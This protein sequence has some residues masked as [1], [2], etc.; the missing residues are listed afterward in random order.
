MPP[1]SPRRYIIHASAAVLFTDTGVRPPSSVFLKLKTNEDEDVN[2]QPLR[3]VH[4]LGSH[5][6]TINTFLNEAKLICRDLAN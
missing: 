1:A 5:E 4:T 3:D 2:H 6:C